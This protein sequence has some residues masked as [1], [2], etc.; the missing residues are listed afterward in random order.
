VVEKLLAAGQGLSLLRIQ[1]ELDAM[2]EKARSEG[3]SKAL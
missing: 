3:R 1:Q 2:R